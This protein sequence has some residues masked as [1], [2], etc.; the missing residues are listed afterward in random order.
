MVGWMVPTL[1]GT[2]GT[3]SIAFTKNATTAVTSAIFTPTAG[4]LL[5]VKGDVVGPDETPPPSP[6]AG[7]SARW[8]EEDL[9][10]MW[11]LC[12]PEFRVTEHLAGRLGVGADG[13]VGVGGERARVALDGLAA[14]GGAVEH[15]R[16]CRP[17]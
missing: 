4:D 12:C 1:S 8:I 10:I 9:L 7:C 16:R 3:H 15:P 14:P 11:S 5:V 2:D 6:A 17:R 13:H